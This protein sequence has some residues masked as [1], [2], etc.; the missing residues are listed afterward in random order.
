MKA[1]LLLNI[2]II[3]STISFAQVPDTIDVV[4][5][6]I[7]V[8]AVK[9]ETEYYGFAEGDRVVFNLYV[10]SGKELKDVTIT[11]YP[12]NV[13][14]AEHTIGKIENK[15]LNVARTGVYSFEYYNSNLSGRTVKIKIQRVPKS[16]N[17]KFFNTNIVWKKVFDTTYSVVS[18]QYLISADTLL[19]T[20]I[21]TKA[22]VHSTLNNPRTLVDFV[23]P[24]NT[25]SWAFRIGVG[26]ESSEA[27]QKD[28]E[29]LSGIG[30]KFVNKANPVAG[31]LLGILPQLTK[32]TTGENVKYWFLPNNESANSFIE[33]KEFLQYKSGEVV[34]DYAKMAPIA[35]R[36]YIGLYNDNTINAIEVTINIEAMV[37]GR[38][39]E[40]RAEKIPFVS[41]KMLP[42]NEY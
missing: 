11:E 8:G 35:G 13:K 15:I 5:K 26:S 32:P 19:Q 28:I 42:F 14:F 24:Q 22:V 9:T 25:V 41:E 23:L 33:K 2:S 40:T 12:K 17:T 27:Y 29:I 30:S 39:Y 18:K 10:E 36:Q 1:F 37:V 20:V 31:F 4:E 6:T 3:L 16:V 34:T 38:K 7:K 21:D